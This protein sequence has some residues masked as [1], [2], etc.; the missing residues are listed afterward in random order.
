M[1]R[2]GTRVSEPGNQGAGVTSW[3]RALVRSSA[4][5]LLVALI[6]AGYRFSA[7]GVGVHVPGSEATLDP[8]AGNARTTEALIAA[9]EQEDLETILA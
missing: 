3:A 6:L 8:V 7:G 5:P 9:L 2:P 1:V 4:V